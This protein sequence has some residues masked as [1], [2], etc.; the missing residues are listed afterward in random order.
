MST[1]R[2]ALHF[3]LTVCAA[4]YE[5]AKTYYREGRYGDLF[6]FRKLQDAGFHLWYSTISTWTAI[7]SLV[8]AFA[9]LERHV[10]GC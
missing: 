3:L 10:R 2:H 4:I 5:S 9:D 8:K 6:S 1:P 7:A